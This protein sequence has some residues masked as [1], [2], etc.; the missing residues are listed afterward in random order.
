[1]AAVKYLQSRHDINPGAVGLWGISQGGW[2]CLMAAATYD[3]VAF[4]IS[5][6][7]PGVTP[8]EQEVYRVQ[9]M[10]LAAGFDDDEVAKAVLMRRLMVDVVLDEPIYQQINL[11]ESN[12]L[13]DGPWR[14]MT[15]LVYGP[16]P[17]DLSIEFEELVRILKSIKAERWARFLYL[18]QVLALFDHMQP[19]DWGMTKSQ[20][21]AVTVVD[22][23]QSLARIHV[24]VLAI[25]GEDDTY[26]PVERS[27]A[28]YQQHLGEAGNQAFTYRVFPDADHGIR[29]GGRFADGYFDLMVDWLR[30][31]P[32]GMGE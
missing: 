26:L 20:L 29:R 7:G 25:F 19:E 32:V 17:K 1:I 14:E 6:S 18:D 21:R 23:A 9:A 12:R 4:I 31:S 13:G 8:A 2:V 5:V 22:P 27:I 11:V 16:Q 10:S 28:A 3:G 30:N 24:P 15:E